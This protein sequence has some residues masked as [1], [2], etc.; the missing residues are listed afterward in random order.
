MRILLSIMLTMLLTACESKPDFTKPLD[1][2]L[3][4]IT[5]TFS[6][7]A[8]HVKLLEQSWANIDTE[9][10]GYRY[11][12]ELLQP[13]VEKGPLPDD[14]LF[15]YYLSMTSKDKIDM[16]SLRDWTA[17]SLEELVVNSTKAAK[18]FYELAEKGYPY[19]L[20]NSWSEGKIITEENMCK[21]P[22]YQKACN[23]Y[24][25][26]NSANV[27]MLAYWHWAKKSNDELAYWNAWI[28]AADYQV[29]SVEVQ[30]KGIEIL[31][32]GVERGSS[33]CAATLAN[34]Y[35]ESFLNRKDYPESYQDLW[36]SNYDFLYP[37]KEDRQKKDY[38]KEMAA[39]YLAIARKGA[40]SCEPRLQRLFRPT[41]MDNSYNFLYKTIKP[42][43]TTE[44]NIYANSC[45]VKGNQ[46][47]LII[48]GELIDK[49][50]PII[51]AALVNAMIPTAEDRRDD[52]NAFYMRKQFKGTKEEIAMSTKKTI[53]LRKQLP[54]FGT[55]FFT[56]PANQ[57][58]SGAESLESLA[59]DGFTVT[60]SFTEQAK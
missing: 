25:S 28:S 55:R 20:G 30:R 41:R 1:E 40:I 26:D 3:P 45:L 56:N 36:R 33:L 12:Y 54:H 18:G 14:L 23:E 43:D 29:N 19:T 13:Y 6:T 21:L 51:G 22:R 9:D 34:L 35:T 59:R 10:D 50:N 8:E 16:A 7:S 39:K 38:T 4:P 53:E 47:G 2:I 58:V 49:N 32:E 11:T 46:E 60:P 15:V 52:D 27:K 31:K 37:N 5:A 42:M 57:S 17:P 24:P 48:A 44:E